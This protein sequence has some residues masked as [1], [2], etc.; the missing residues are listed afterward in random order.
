MQDAAMLLEACHMPSLPTLVAGWQW[1]HC[2]WKSTTKVQITCFV[3]KKQFSCI[4]IEE[5]KFVHSIEE[6]IYIVSL[7]EKRK[8]NVCYMISLKS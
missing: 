8:G 3:T 2:T 4:L 5:I 7:D 6:N 1:L